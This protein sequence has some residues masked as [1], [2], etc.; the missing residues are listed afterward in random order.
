MSPFLTDLVY[1]YIITHIMHN[2]KYLT[3]DAECAIIEVYPKFRR[4]MSKQSRR[5]SRRN[6]PSREE[7]LDAREQ[8]GVPHG[9]PEGGSVRHRLPMNM[10]EVRQL[11]SAK[12]KHKYLRMPIG[13]KENR[14]WDKLWQFKG[15]PYNKTPF[16]GD[17]KRRKLRQKNQ[18]KSWRERNNRA[19]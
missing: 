13:R 18:S 5:E 11:L 10:N 1:T 12:G 14:Y 9:K 19:A 7:R 3:F 4:I 15:R 6:R 8:A 2:V 17:S 16:K